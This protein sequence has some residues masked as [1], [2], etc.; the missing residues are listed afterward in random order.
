MRGV[1][2]KWITCT[3]SALICETI[4]ELFHDFFKNSAIFAAVRQW[5]MSMLETFPV[6]KCAMPSTYSAFRDR[7]T[8]CSVYLG[9]VISLPWTNPW[10]FPHV[11]VILL[12]SLSCLLSSTWIATI[13]K[14]SLWGVIVRRLPTSYC[15]VFIM[16]NSHIFLY[17][18]AILYFWSAITWHLPEAVILVYSYTSTPPRLYMRSAPT[19]ADVCSLRNCRTSSY[20]HHSESCC[21]S[22]NGSSG[23]VGVSSRGTTWKPKDT[24]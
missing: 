5:H 18:K 24:P 20:G 2:H 12:F 21:I 7:L 9:S 23:G 16:C 6:H 15:M 17:K 11:L 10:P 1:N 3:S 8:L 14:S 19:Q 22:D 13:F 4:A